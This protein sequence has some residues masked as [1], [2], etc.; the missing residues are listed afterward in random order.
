[1]HSLLLFTCNLCSLWD[2][3]PSSLLSVLLL[4]FYSSVG[5]PLISSWR[6]WEERQE[7]VMMIQ[8]VKNKHPH[9]KKKEQKICKNILPWLMCGCNCLSWRCGKNCCGWLN[10]TLCNCSHWHTSS[11]A[12]KQQAKPIQTERYEPDVVLVWQCLLEMGQSNLIC[13]F[14]KMPSYTSKKFKLMITF[15]G[16]WKIKNAVGSPV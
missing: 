14:L 8:A 12:M 16:K 13:M 15:N 3:F 11:V 5:L 1:M 9:W 4:K 10:F 6:N 2:I 7:T